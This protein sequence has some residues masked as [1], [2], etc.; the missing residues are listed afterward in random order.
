MGGFSHKKH[1]AQQRIKYY[2]DRISQYQANVLE[3][4]SKVGEQK[5]RVEAAA[6]AAEE[7]C[8]RVETDR[9]RK[10]IQSEIDKLRKRIDEELPQQAEQDKI[11][12]QYMEAMQRYE[13]TSDAIRNEQTALKV[14]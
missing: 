5:E 7:V 8:A 4:E 13:R 1:E 10:S 9:S 6:R 11:T 14:T 12:E 2:Q 3:L